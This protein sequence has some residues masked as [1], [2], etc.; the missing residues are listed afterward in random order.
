MAPPA[1]RPGKCL[2][3]FFFFFF[4]RK[5][6]LQPRASGSPALGG[7]PGVG[8]QVRR[9]LWS[10]L[11]GG[12]LTAP[13][14]AL[15][16]SRANPNTEGPT[17]TQSRS[18]FCCIL[19][20]FWKQWGCGGDFFRIFSGLSPGGRERGRVAWQVHGRQGCAHCPA[21]CPE[22]RPRARGSRRW[23]LGL[24]TATAMARHRGTSQRA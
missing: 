24:L 23:V 22:P 9:V 12:G 14:G 10:G 2:T 20:L 5:Q 7:S 17:G 18:L 6:N 13:L 16:G 21:P 15:L 8:A 1:A 19:W 3:I 11:Q 4:L